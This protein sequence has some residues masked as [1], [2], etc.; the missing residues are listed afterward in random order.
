MMEEN[1]KGFSPQEDVDVFMAAA[2]QPMRYEMPEDPST[3]FDEESAILYKNLIVEE[4]HE[5]IAAFADKDIV[6][7]ADGLA[8][9]VWVILGLCST[10]GID[11]YKVWDAVW[12]SN[13]SKVQNGRLI[14]NP[15]TGKVMKPHT[16]FEPKIREALGLDVD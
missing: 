8:D 6:E 16:Y 7:L 9:M 10:M 12:E 2:E 4:F 1:K 5:T 15:E 13:M 11:F 14:K 3:M